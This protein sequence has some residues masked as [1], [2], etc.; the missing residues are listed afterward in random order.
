MLPGFQFR[1]Q[2]LYRKFNPDK[3]VDDPVYQG[4]VLPGY[5][6]AKQRAEIFAKQLRALGINPD[7]ILSQSQ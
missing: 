7:E 4:F 5:S 6:E 2:D 1:K 3:M